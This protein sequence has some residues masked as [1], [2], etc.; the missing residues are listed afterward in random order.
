MTDQ[1]FEALIQRREKTPTTEVRLPASKVRRMPANRRRQVMKQ[2]V[3]VAL[4]EYEVFET[5]DDLVEY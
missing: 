1:G 2:A 3:A 4:K 5:N